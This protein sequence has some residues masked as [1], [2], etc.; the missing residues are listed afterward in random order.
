MNNG[1]VRCG[2]TICNPVTGLYVE[3]PSIIGYYNIATIPDGA[4]NISILELKNSENYLGE[5][6][7]KNLPIN[8]CV[9]IENKA[10]HKRFQS[11]LISLALNTC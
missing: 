8:I 2:A 9:E 11:D 10:I 1:A 4:S 5:L 6:N 7:R 3:N